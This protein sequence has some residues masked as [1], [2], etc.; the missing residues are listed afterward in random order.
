MT[1]PLL[2]AP[3]LGVTSI[4]GQA[5]DVPA[6]APPAERVDPGGVWL[7]AWTGSS[8]GTSWIVIRAVEGDRYRAEDLRGRGFEFELDE[9]GGLRVTGPPGTE[10][11][12]RFPGPDRA[13]YDVTI[14]PR[15][16]AETEPRRAAG[17]RSGL[18]LRAPATD[19][20][21]AVPGPSSRPFAGPLTLAGTWNALG[22]EISPTTGEV[23]RERSL[24][25]EIEV[26]EAQIRLAFADGGFDQGVFLARD[27]FWFHVVHPPVP[28]VNPSLEGAMVTTR[29]HDLL[30]LGRV[31][32]DALELRFFLETR[33]AVG[34]RVQ[35]MYHY[36]FER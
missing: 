36:R 26:R 29:N 24:T 18:L 1:L 15:K 11:A 7:H 6:P 27:R 28:A 25:C 16:E 5:S 35:M 8:S 31:V 17:R 30:G 10:G 12:G 23:L 22:R 21:L 4:L 14:A 13:V 2:V 34:R 20:G 9:E 3:L 32:G 33:G 19:R